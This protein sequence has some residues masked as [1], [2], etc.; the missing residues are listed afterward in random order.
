MP[1]PEE[2]NKSQ[3]VEES[4]ELDEED[5]AILDSVWDKINEEDQAAGGD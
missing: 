5:D 1:E 4:P 3:K 2:Q